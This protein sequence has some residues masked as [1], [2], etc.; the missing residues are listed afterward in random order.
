MTTPPVKIRIDIVSDVVC[1]WCVIGYK[2]L[3]EALSRLE[4]EVKAEIHWH[5]FELNPMIPPEGQELREHMGQKYGTNRQQSDAARERIAKVGNALGFSFNFYEGQRIYNTF[6]AH[7]LLKWA[8]Q[9]GKQAELELALFESYFSQQ[10]NVGEAK[11]LAE[12]ASRVG[13]DQVEAAAVIEDGRYAAEVREHQRFWLSKGIQA[14]P[15]FI[16]DRR[17]LI[18]GAQDPDVFVAALEKLS[19]EEAP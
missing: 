10:E 12:V 17:Y 4:G 3:Q 6:L 2:Q 7:Q 13:L 11:V 16:L 19:E 1:P 5:P 14:V 8:E 15:S 9:Q 18:P